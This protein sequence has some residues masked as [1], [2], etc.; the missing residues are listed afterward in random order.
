VLDGR[1]V[2]I[3]N[4]LP[5]IRLQKEKVNFNGHSLFLG[6]LCFWSLLVSKLEY[7]DFGGFWKEL[8]ELSSF[9]V[10]RLDKV[11]YMQS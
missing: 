4:F 10:V 2:G 5:K 8:L 1:K 11:S 3:A 7:Q 9:V 6:V